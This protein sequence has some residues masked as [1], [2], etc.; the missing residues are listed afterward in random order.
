MVGWT[1]EENGLGGGQAYRDAHAA[2]LDKHVVAIES[3]GGVFRPTGFGSPAATG[4][5]RCV[6]EIV[7]L[8]KPIGADT[9]SSA[10]RGRADIGPIMERGR[11]RRSGH[12]VDGT[13]YF[14]YHH[15]EATPSTSSTRARSP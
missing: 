8:L 4:R 15:T 2:E 7:A 10:R 11:A 5:A 14:W 1:N 3:D 13:R 6:R 9:V 12:E